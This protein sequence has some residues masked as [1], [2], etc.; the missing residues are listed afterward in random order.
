M[1]TLDTIFYIVGAGVC[2]AI[3]AGILAAIIISRIEIRNRLL[4]L[5]NLV[6]IEDTRVKHFLETAG[7]KL[8]KIVGKLY[9]AKKIKE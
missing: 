6:Y 8:K 3:F 1:S 4:A 2:T 9:Y 5:L 7:W